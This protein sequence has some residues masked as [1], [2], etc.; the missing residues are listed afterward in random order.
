MPFGVSIGHNAAAFPYLNLS[1]LCFWREKGAGV[2]RV[3]LEESRFP[4]CVITPAW[5]E[6]KNGKESVNIAP[7]SHLILRAGGG[8]HPTF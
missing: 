6:T 8:R 5:K 7:Y 3:S 4:S 1:N 2:G